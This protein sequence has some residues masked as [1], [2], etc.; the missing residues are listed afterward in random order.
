[1]SRKKAAHEETAVSGDDRL[2]LDIS[3]PEHGWATISLKI[4]DVELAFPASYTPCDSIGDLARAAG[5]L[6]TAG[7]E[8]VV[9]WKS[10]PVE[11]EFRFMIAGDRT[12]LEVRSFADRRRTM[13]GPQ[14]IMAFDGEATAIASVIWR[15]LRR[16]E[17]AIA[18][19]DFAAA[20]GHPFPH[21]TV[22]RLGQELRRAAKAL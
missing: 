6:V 8:Q 2:R 22:E 15:S 10:E 7:S 5:A 9:T 20:W 4:R 16:L 17:G 1:V 18:H 13:P 11:Y 3:L 19:D 21:A 14:P 12:R